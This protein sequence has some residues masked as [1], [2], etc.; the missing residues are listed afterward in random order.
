MEFDTNCYRALLISFSLIHFLTSTALVL[1]AAYLTFWND[2][3]NNGIVPDKYQTT[4]FIIGFG[5]L[6][7]FIAS[8]Y[9]GLFPIH[10]LQ[11]TILGFI[12]W[13]ASGLSRVKGS[14]VYIFMLGVSLFLLLISAFCFLYMANFDDPAISLSK[15]L[16]EMVKMEYNKNDN[17]AKVSL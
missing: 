5:A 13:F 17:I 14:I 3:F 7:S 4:I 10:F 2:Y 9:K 15:T 11:S 12:G 8:E 6:L 16:D 1:L